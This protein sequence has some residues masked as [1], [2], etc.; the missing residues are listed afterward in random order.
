MKKKTERKE[1][2]NEMGYK[3]THTQIHECS[4]G[5]KERKRLCLP[6]FASDFISICAGGDSNIHTHHFVITI[7]K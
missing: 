4:F 1:K 6:Q 5:R 2:E 7:M 3:Y